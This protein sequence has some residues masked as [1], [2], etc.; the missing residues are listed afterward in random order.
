MNIFQFTEHSQ[1]GVQ[2]CKSVNDLVCSPVHHELCW[3]VTGQTVE[4]KNV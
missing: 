4:N 2:E 3:D 1:D